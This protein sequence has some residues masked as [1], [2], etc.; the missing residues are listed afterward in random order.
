M[1]NLKLNSIFAIVLLIAFSSCKKNEGDDD[2][3]LKPVTTLVDATSYTDWVY[4]SLSENRIVE[5]S[6]PSTST[7]WDIALMRSHFRTNSGTS[8]NANGG[9][10][11]AGVVNF[12]TY[13]Q[14]PEAGYIVDTIIQVFNVNTMEY[15]SVSANEVLEYW[16]SLS[17]N[18]PPT[19]TPNNKVFA[20]KTASGKYA[21]ISILSYY[22]T[23]GS[24][25]ITF[26]YLYQ[27]NGSR[28]LE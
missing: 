24:G 9:V 19:F 28:I 11:D 4:Y 20:L 23:G 16:G 3:K 14:A 25:Y 21:K 2:N 22:G 5:V 17:D 15:R 12:N 6:D 26:K 10:F 13:T 7:S 8:G 18:M 1:R 27:P